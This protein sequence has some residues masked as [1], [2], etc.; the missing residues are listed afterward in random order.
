ML[1]FTIRDVLWLM[2]VAALGLSWWVDNARIEKAV[3]K[4]EG[5]RRDLQADFEDRITILNSPR[6]PSAKIAQG[7][8]RQLN[9][10]GKPI[11]L[12]FDDVVSGKHISMTDLRGKVVVIE[13]WSA[14]CGPCL[15]EMPSLRSTFSKYKEE[16]VEFIGVNLDH[17]SVGIKAVRKCI[18]DHKMT[19]PQYYQGD[20]WES[21]FS[22]S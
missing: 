22:Q 1:R 20:G 17:P 15:A 18:A 6:K 13:F 16:G 9:G 11:E 10:I 3:T 4:L 8:L 21:E 12:S 19:W 7:E 14:T 5:E 2:V